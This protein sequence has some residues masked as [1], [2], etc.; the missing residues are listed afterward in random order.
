MVQK[1]FTEFRC[2]RT[3]TK[4]IPNPDRPNKITTPEMMNKIPDI[5]LNDPKV[6]GRKIAQIVYISNERVNNILHT[7][8]CMRKFCA[9]WVPRLLTIDQKQS[10][11]PGGKAPKR[12]KMQQSTENVTV[13]VFWDAHGVILIDYLKKGRTITGSYYAALLG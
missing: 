8:L 13:S 2:G 3:S 6:K 10:V 4:I 5:I 11:K 1:W 9:R 7:H 12:P